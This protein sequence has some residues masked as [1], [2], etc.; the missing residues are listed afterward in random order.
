MSIHQAQVT[1][2]TDKYISAA[3]S[4]RFDSKI[5]MKRAGKASMVIG[6]GW[7]RVVGVN[8]CVRAHS[9][10]SNGASIRYI[11]KCGDGHGGTNTH[12]EKVLRNKFNKY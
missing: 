12:I 11:W 4:I 6:M 7:D 2:E 9:S 10:N 8:M 5:E 3:E 1:D